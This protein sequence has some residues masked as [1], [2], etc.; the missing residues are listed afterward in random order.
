MATKESSADL[1]LIAQ[2]EKLFVIMQAGV[3]INPD[4][5]A[6]NIK[7]DIEVLYTGIVW[8]IKKF[9][10]G[11]VQTEVFPEHTAMILFGRIYFTVEFIHCRR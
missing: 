10:T 3:E 8:L 2:V 9:L 4:N 5:L 7:S 1:L 6:E 11:S